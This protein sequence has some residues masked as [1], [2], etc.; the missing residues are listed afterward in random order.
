MAKR[1]NSRSK[2][3]AARHRGLG[4]LF[5][6]CLAVIVVAVGI[7]SRAPLEAALARRF[8]NGGGTSGAPN[9]PPQVTVAPLPDT[10]V[11]PADAGQSARVAPSPQQAEPAQK[12]KAAAPP[13]EAAATRKSRL[14][15]ATVDPSGGITMKSVIR[16]IPASDAPLRDA[17]ESL[18]KG[19]TA[20]EMNLGMVSMIPAD[21]KLR[22]VT[23]RGE[24]AFVDFSQ[25]FRFNALGIEALDAQLR[26]VV[27]V[28]TEF[29]S[30]KR[31]QILIEGKKVQYL[32]TEGI[33][34]SEPLAR[35]SFGQ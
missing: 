2:P 23:V 28:A 8:G 20:L 5:W 1:K 25:S 19:P 17:M 10:S 29:P 35:A 14:F 27:Y 4:L 11:P 30:V 18:L 22:G 31:V 13:V 9:V 33:R 21:A 6:L 7:A 3:G 24:T 15:F 26:Q 32:G 16:P 34:I 12:K